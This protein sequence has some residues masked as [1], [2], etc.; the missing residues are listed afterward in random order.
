MR[1]LPEMISSRFRQVGCI[2][3][4]C[5]PD[6]LYIRKQQQA[7]DLP[8]GNVNRQVARPTITPTRKD[9]ADAPAN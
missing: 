7:D 2:R 9:H 1:H 8:A 6:I 4:A 3:P 5:L